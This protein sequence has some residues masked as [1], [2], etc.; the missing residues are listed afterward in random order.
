MR[1]RTGIL[2]VRDSDGRQVT[3]AKSHILLFKRD[4]H[5][6]GSDACAQQARQ[7]TRRRPEARHV[8]VPVL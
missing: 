7:K 2:T 4:G 3:A 8:G 1:T 5:V 6:H